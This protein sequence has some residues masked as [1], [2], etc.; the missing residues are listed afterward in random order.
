MIVSGSY[1]VFLREKKCS[2]T[3]GSSSTGSTGSYFRSSCKGKTGSH[4]QPLR[5]VSSGSV[6]T[7]IPML[8]PYST[9][10]TPKLSYTMICDWTI[11]LNL[12][13]VC[14]THEAVLL[15]PILISALPFLGKNVFQ[16]AH[17][18]IAIQHALQ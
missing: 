18:Y 8:L 11:I 16:E 2:T 14:K 6:R 5:P 3:T 12:V 15:P 9:S 13:H 7:G 4:G 17:N 1:L 10:F